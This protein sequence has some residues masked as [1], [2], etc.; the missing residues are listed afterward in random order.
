MYTQEEHIKSGCRQLELLKGL[1]SRMF[2]WL[3]R[4]YLFEVQSHRVHPTSLTGRSVVVYKNIITFMFRFVYCVPMNECGLTYMTLWCG[5]V[6]FFFL[7]QVVP[8]FVLSLH[9]LEVFMRDHFA[10]LRD[11]WTVSCRLT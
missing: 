8:S 2:C 5:L 6:Y 1:L 10:G 3:V 9:V 11:G 7:Q 4:W